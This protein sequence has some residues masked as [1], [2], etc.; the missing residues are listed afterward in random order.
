MKKTGKLQAVSKVVSTKYVYEKA[1]SYRIAPI[2]GAGG[3]VSDKGIF[4]ELYYERPGYPVNGGVDVPNVREVQFG[5]VLNID[6]AEA[7]S[8]WFN[9]MIELYKQQKEMLK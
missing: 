3:A 8:A 7:L 2:S 1:P 6:E 9:K 4:V 5:A